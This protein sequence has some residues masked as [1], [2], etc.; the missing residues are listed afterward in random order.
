MAISGHH[1]QKRVD[2]FS[3]I[4]PAAPSSAPSASVLSPST[5]K[6]LNDTY[7]WLKD[8]GPLA[9]MPALTRGLN[10][11]LSA[12]S[13]LALGVYHHLQAVDHFRCLAL[14]GRFIQKGLHLDLCVLG[15][16]LAPSKF[17]LFGVV[18]P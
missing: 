7:G 6:D 1:P 13:A 9:L 14:V 10:A 5:V 16:Q 12:L 8:A 18:V 3:E 2:S 17:K 15:Q 11:R 4:H